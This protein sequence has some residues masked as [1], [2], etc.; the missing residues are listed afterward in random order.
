MR[1]LNFKNVDILNKKM[2]FLIL[3]WLL[4]KLVMLLM[5]WFYNK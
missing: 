5:F 4:D 1:R 3:L 2:T